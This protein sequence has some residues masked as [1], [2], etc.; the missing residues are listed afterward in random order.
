MNIAR[1]DESE[2]QRLKKLLKQDDQEQFIWIRSLLNAAPNATDDDDTKWLRLALRQTTLSDTD[3][4][5]L[6][7]VLK[8]KRREMYQFYAKN[9]GSDFIM[10]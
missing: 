4:E 6:G 5:K 1:E 2:Y 8:K 10:L 3:R 9:M 7:E